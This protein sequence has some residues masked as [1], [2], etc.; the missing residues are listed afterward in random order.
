MRSV[1]K[2]IKVV[3]LAGLLFLIGKLFKMI[4]ENKRREGRSL[5]F[6]GIDETFKD[7]VPQECRYNLLFSGLNF[8]FREMEN[9]PEVI[10]LNIFGRFSGFN[11][12]I[13]TDWNVELE[14]TEDKS[15][16]NNA[17]ENHD[18][19]KTTLK[20]TYDLKYSGLNIDQT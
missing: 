15:G 18:E 19:A 12:D 14:G 7:K 20:I 16:I 3:L 13:P 8:D 9:P 10:E 1:F 11:I 5:C 4:Y 2:F 17:V 6:F